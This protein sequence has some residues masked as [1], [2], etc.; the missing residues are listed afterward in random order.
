M[1]HTY[2]VNSFLQLSIHFIL[3]LNFPIKR[4]MVYSSIRSFVLWA[5]TK[6][7]TVKT[8]PQLASEAS[9]GLCSE[10]GVSRCQ[11]QRLLIQFGRCLLPAHYHPSPFSRRSARSKGTVFYFLSLS[12]PFRCARTGRRARCF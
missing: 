4:Q 12:Q 3:L 10:Q 1:S 8:R 2:I 6:L 7:S 11:T 5:A 9:R